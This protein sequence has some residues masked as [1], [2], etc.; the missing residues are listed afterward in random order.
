[1][2]FAWNPLSASSA[3]EPGQNATSD[4]PPMYLALVFSHGEVLS[5]DLL[6]TPG[7]FFGDAGQTGGAG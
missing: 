2:R 6:S 7:K 5:L 4:R 3:R 1:M